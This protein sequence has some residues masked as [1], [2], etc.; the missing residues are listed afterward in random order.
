MYIQNGNQGQQ[1]QCRAVAR[2]AKRV[3]IETTDEKRRLAVQHL[4]FDSE[5]QAIDLA[6]DIIGKQ[7]AVELAKNVRFL[8]LCKAVLAGAEDLEGVS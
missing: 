8:N 7:P 1:R 4:Q 6:L 2:H 3:T 5:S